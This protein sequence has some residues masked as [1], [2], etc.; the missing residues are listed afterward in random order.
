MLLSVYG[1]GCW[2]EDI[3]IIIRCF[4]YLSYLRFSLE[5]IVQSIYGFDRT[6]MI[7]PSDEHFCPYKKP[8]FLLRIMGFEDINIYVSISALIL[9]FLTFNIIAILLIKSRLS[10]RRRTFWPIQIVSEVVKTYFNFTPYKF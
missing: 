5:G 8:S 4:M 3:P 6:D 2:K 1:I 7:C 10:R 9:Y